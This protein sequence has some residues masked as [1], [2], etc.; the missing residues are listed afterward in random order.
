MDTRMC[1]KKHKTDRRWEKA[2]N[3]FTGLNRQSAI[4]TTVSFL[5][6]Y[7]SLFPQTQA[8]T[9]HY[10]SASSFQS[11]LEGFAQINQQF[12]VS[13]VLTIDSIDS[14]IMSAKL[15]SEQTKKLFEMNIALSQPNVVSR[16][17]L[18]FERVI[19]SLKQLE[20]TF[21]TDQQLDVR[22]LP[23]VDFADVY[24]GIYE[25]TPLNTRKGP[26]DR[27]VGDY[28]AFDHNSVSDNE[29]PKNYFYNK[30]SISIGISR[31]IA[32]DTSDKVAISSFLNKATGAITFPNVQEGLQLNRTK[33]ED[34]QLNS[35]L[36]LWPRNPLSMEVKSYGANSQN[37]LEYLNTFGNLA[38]SVNLPLVPRDILVNQLDLKV[39]W[40]NGGT[41]SNQL[42]ES[43]QLITEHNRES[44]EAFQSRIEDQQTKFSTQQ[45]K[46]QSEL[47]NQ[48]SQ[49]YQNSSY[50]Q[51]RSQQVPGLSRYQTPKTSLKLTPKNLP[52]APRTVSS[53][54][55]SNSFSS[56]NNTSTSN[57]NYNRSNLTRPIQGVN[58]SLNKKSSISPLSK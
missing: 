52:L 36:Q 34:Q 6:S 43:T 20:F 2:M 44:Q 28:L 1:L 42:R 26:V 24:E 29:L 47:Q 19:N 31:A 25:F 57:N 45:Q 46:Y 39:D 35:M 30:N 23:Q 16:S 5:M 51:Q 21:N 9:L 40:V 37:N 54:Q 3:K 48:M 55:N 8:A 27:L 38:V 11:S 50:Q 58:N 32:S 41:Y 49:S 17:A 15:S 56:S 12:L 4:V 14:Q 53:S 22:T 33:P 13:N 7:V 10:P 18:S